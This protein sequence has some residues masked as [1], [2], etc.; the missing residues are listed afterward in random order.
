ML[1]QRSESFALRI[2]DRASG[3][4]TNVNPPENKAI[5]ESA[6]VLWTRDMELA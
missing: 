3:Y 6:E 1:V 5:D 2:W 4:F